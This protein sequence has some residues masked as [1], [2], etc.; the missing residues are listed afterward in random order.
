MKKVLLSL[1]LVACLGYAANAQTTLYSEDFN[2]TSGTSLP[3]GWTQTGSGWVTGTPSEVNSSSFGVP[4]NT[5]GRVLIINDDGAGQGVDNSNE[6]V[7]TGSINLSAGTASNLYLKFDLVY[8]GLTYQGDTESLTLEVS[9]D[10]GSSWNVLSTLDANP[11]TAWHPRYISLANYA[12]NA[13]VMFGFR[14]SD[15]GGWLFGA[16]VDNINI[17][18]VLNNDLSL[19]S[20]TPVQGSSIAYGAVGSDKSINGVVFNGGANNIT[21]YV[22]KYQQGAS[23]VQSYTKS[24]TMAPFSNDTFTHNIPFTI[25]SVGEFPINVWVELSG[26]ENTTNNNADA[27]VQGVANMP[28]K[29]ILFEEGTGT[30][31]GWCPRGTVAMDEFAN[32]HPGAAAQVA[33]HNNDP[34]SVSAYDGFIGTMISGYPSMVVDRKY[35]VDP[36]QLLDA[37]NELQDGFGFAEITLG[38]VSISGG[39]ATVPVTIV[40][41][42]N[43]DG[44][45]VALIVT[46]SNLSGPAGSNWDQANYYAGGG[47]GPMGGFENEA[48]SVPNTKYHFVGRSITPSPTGGASG[49]PATMV[50]ETPYELSLTANI[51]AAWNQDN[52][53][54]IVV[55]LSSD[56]E[57][58]NTAFTDIPGLD[59]VLPGGTAISNIEAGINNMEVYPNPTSDMLNVVFDMNQASSLHITV[60]DITG[61]VVYTTDN[62][63][64]PG[65]NNLQIGTSSFSNGIYLLNAQTENGNATLKFVVSH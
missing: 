3:S 63:L 43:I 16:A 42:I 14:Y 33:V 53:Q 58:L 11:T 10:G 60:T 1:S 45:K 35:V 65:Q 6:L 56:D 59:P 31:C 23:P 41:S 55:L 57:A 20:V 27:F 51:N 48:S 46:E 44:A 37:Y 17:M 49:L 62:K 50:A 2:S 52:L 15:G 28:T 9:T 19:V 34:M 7:K 39:V 40:P 54:F 8:W 13:N 61:K 32:T 5:D 12:G 36:S 25:P 38:N 21:S 18:N 64:T 4:T 29:R 24:V 30:W 47:Q 22:V 26:D